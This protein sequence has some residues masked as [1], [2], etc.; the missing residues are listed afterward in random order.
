MDSIHDSTQ[1][2][3]FKILGFLMNIL[4]S[5]LLLGQPGNSFL[6]FFEMNVHLGG[7]L[8]RVL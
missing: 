5:C 1:L 7:L 6:P 4:L 3:L 8:A 2:F